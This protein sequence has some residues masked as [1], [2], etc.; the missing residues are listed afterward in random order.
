[1]PSRGQ[2]LRNLGRR[3]GYKPA[4]SF[5][6]WE[7]AGR[8]WET[9]DMPAALIRWGLCAVACLLSWPAPALADTPPAPPIVS[10]LEWGSRAK[11]FPE[12]M[13]HVPRLI[14]VHHEGV[15]W[16]PGTE[17]G[18]KLRALQ[19][20][21][22]REKGWLDVPY[23]YAIAPDGQIL[24]GRDWHYRPDSNTS[25]SLD[26]VLNVELMGNFETEL[27]SRRQLNS[28]IALLANLCQTHSLTPSEVTSHRLMAPGQT[29]CPGRD[30]QRY[31]DGPLRVWVRSAMKGVPTN[32]EPWLWPLPEGKL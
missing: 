32:V 31:I 12:E 26:G 29:V 20:W 7:R 13:R 28:L 8:R 6:A 15:A 23:H 16:K 25:Y 17:P 19:S 11:P 5:F 22:A 24:E 9:R 18:A 3:I 4:L 21:G 1:M 27:V 30:L 10:A 2:N 14:V